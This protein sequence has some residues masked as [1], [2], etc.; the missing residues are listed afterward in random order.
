MKQ[1]RFLVFFRT[2]RWI[3]VGTK[4]YYN[5]GDEKYWE[6]VVFDQYYNRVFIMVKF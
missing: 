6:T 3:A 4:L 2:Q 5:H 1:M